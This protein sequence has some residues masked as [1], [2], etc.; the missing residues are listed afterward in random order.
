VQAL[1]VVAVACVVEVA[2]AFASDEVEM[3]LE[4][5]LAYHAASSVEVRWGGSPSWASADAWA[6]RIP[7]EA[8]AEGK[9][10]LAE[11]DRQ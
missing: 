9:R 4:S 11:A 5:C 7:C 3:A 2:A 6:E 1:E 10:H 8:V